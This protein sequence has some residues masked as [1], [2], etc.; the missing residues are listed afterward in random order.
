M[1]ENLT[2]RLPCLCLAV[3][4][5]TTACR[6]SGDPDD[7]R[8]AAANDRRR[9]DDDYCAAQI[10][11]P[12]PPLD[13]QTPRG[14]AIFSLVLLNVPS[15][16]RYF[17]IASQLLAKQQAKPITR[18]VVLGSTLEGRAFGQSFS[19]VEFPSMRHFDAFYCA[20]D[21]QPDVR[22]IRLGA[23]NLLFSVAKE[24]DAGSIGADTA[25]VKGSVKGFAYFN[26]VVTDQTAYD[27]YLDAATTLA[28]ASGGTR[29]FSGHGHVE[30]EGY[31]DDKPDNLTLFVFPSMAK[32]R[33]WYDSP[34]YQT[35]K[36]ERLKASQ[37]KF[38]LAAEG[39][40]P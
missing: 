17:S 20:P 31:P 24:G 32:L 21:Y 18:G 27:R 37:V 39:F 1:F 34:A 38:V 26:D 35:L 3:I 40:V 16:L 8:V 19:I 11:A 15:Y 12:R 14:Y 30:V 9:L 22:R 6:T 28:A 29:L 33:E 23:G 10:Q 5:T 25:S 36:A 2:F 7:S 4:M 13:E